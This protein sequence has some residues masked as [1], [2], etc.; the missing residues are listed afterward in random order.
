M[1]ENLFTDRQIQ[2]LRYRKS[3]LTQQQIA[4]IFHTSKANIC[5]IEKAAR[6]NVLR[7]K[8]TLDLF[9]TL[10][11]RLICTIRAGSDLFDT[12]PRIIDEAKNAGMNLKIDPMDIINRVR[13]EFP[14]RIHGR[15]IKQDIEVYLETS[16]WL[17]FA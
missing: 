2:V 8:K 13:E 17:V 9:H 15:L 3:G 14:G 16:G 1:A 12:V 10:D 6:E 11:A 7:A 4:D 5:T